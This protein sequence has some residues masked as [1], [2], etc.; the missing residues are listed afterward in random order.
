MMLCRQVHVGRGVEL[1]SGSLSYSPG[2]CRHHRQHAS[3]L[4]MR[5]DCPQ[6][7]ALC[8]EGARRVCWRVVLCCN[9]EHASWPGALLPL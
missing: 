9:F 8:F 4:G 3:R 7:R 1:P 5:H 2:V 6:R